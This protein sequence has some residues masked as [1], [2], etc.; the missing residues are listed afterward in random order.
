[1]AFSLF[2]SPSQKILLLIS[3]S[4]RSP[5]TPLSWFGLL[6]VRSPLLRE[7]LLISVPG[8]LR[9]FTSPSLTLLSYFIQIRSTSEDVG[10]PIR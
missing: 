10:Y 3:I 5:T 4:R 9:W 6:P 8:L 1:M 2:D 7:S